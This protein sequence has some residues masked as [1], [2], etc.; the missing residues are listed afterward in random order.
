MSYCIVVAVTSLRWSFRPFWCAF[1]Q[2]HRHLLYISCTPFF[3]SSY[4]ARAL[5]PVFVSTGT[6]LYSQ[7]PFY[8]TPCGTPRM[9]G[10][11]YEVEKRINTILETRTQ[12]RL[13]VR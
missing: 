3:F 12:S 5:W 13:R 2:R 9:R 10:E 4:H 1:F 6:C 7:P 11:L 8:F